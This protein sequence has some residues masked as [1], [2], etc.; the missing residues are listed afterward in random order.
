MN[1]PNLVEGREGKEYNSGRGRNILVKKYYFILLARIILGGSKF[2]IKICIPLIISKYMKG[3][4]Y[5]FVLK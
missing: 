4:K 2:R 1:G 3:S 5:I